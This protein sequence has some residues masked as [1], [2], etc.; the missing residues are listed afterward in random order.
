MDGFVGQNIQGYEIHEQINEGGFGAVYRADQS[1]IGREVAIKVILP[2]LASK[3][4]FIRRFEAEAQIIARLEHPHI[5]PLHDYWRDPHG[6][7]LVM[8]YLRGGSLHDVLHQ[9]GSFQIE[10]AVSLFSQIAHGLHIA[11]RNQVV[12]RDIKP[13][14]IL[15]DE[16]GNGYLADFG[17]A[18]D[19]A[20]THNITEP[21]SLVGSPEYLAP[22]QARSEPVTPQTDIYS[23]G[24]VLYEM[25]TGEHPFPGLE[26][27]EVVFKHLNEPLPNIT[28]LEERICSDINSVI[29]K[30]TAKDP[31]KRYKDVLE[32]L[33]A[34]RQ[35]SRLGENVTPTRLVELLTPREQEVM[36]LIIDGKTNREIA[37][38]LVLAETTIKSYI[39][40]IYKKLNVRSRVQAIARARDIDFVIN[41]PDASKIL[42]TGSLPE[43]EN[44]YKGLRAF[45]AAD[46]H[47]FF[48]R[49]KLIRMLVGR[50]GENGTYQRFLSLVG[51]SGSGKS[52]VVRAGLIP[53][54]WRGDLLGSE[55]WYIVDVL[56]G[57]RP[58]DELEVALYRIA[59]DSSVNLR[60]Q[61]ERDEHGLI[62]AS[63]MILPDDGSELLV[64]IDQFE[65]VFTLV[66]NEAHRQHFLDLL[67]ESIVAPRSRV[68]IVVTLR[69]DYYDR[70]LQYPHFGDLMRNR[71]ETI[72][73]LSAEE[74]EKAISEPATRVGVTF[75][76]GLVSRIVSDVHYQPG[77]L[78]LLQYALTELFELREGRQLTL[79]GYTQ[80]GG[81]GGALAKRAD[82][83][84][85]EGDDQSREMIRQ[86]FLRLVT[87]GEGAEDTRRRVER[88]ELLQLSTEPDLMDEII[89]SYAMSRL[90]SLDNDPATRQPIVEVAHEAILREWD[91]LRQWLNE[92]RE[93]IR[94]E[95][96]IAQVASSWQQND[97]DTSYLLS[98]SRLD[99]AIQWQDETQLALMPI[100]SQ[101]IMVSEQEAKSRQEAIEKQQ[102]REAKLERRSQRIL[103]A[104]VGVFA[105]ATIIALGLSIFAINSRNE[106]TSERD[107]AQRVSL[108]AQGQVVLLSG[109]APELAAMLA[110]ESLKRGYSAEADSILQ[111]ALQHG[112]AQQEF[113]GHTDNI[114]NAEFTG[115]GQKLIS[116]S[117]DNTAKLWDTSTGEIL[118][119]FTH[120]NKP[121]TGVISADGHYAATSGKDGNIMIW[122]LQDE[123]VLQT[124]PHS[125]RF[126]WVGPFSH[127]NQYITSADESDTVILWDVR[128]GNMV[129]E[130]TSPGDQFGDT[131]ISPDGQY[132][133]GVGTKVVLWDT[134][135]GEVA[136]RFYGHTGLAVYADI[137]ADGKLLLTGSADRTARLWDIETGLEVRRFEGHTD[138]VRGVDLSP[139]N[140][141]SV[142]G[143]DDGV[144]RVWHNESG[145]VVKQFNLPGIVHSAKFTPDGTQIITAGSD[146]V[147]RLWQLQDHSEPRVFADRFISPKRN[148]TNLGAIT[149]AGNQ[150][151]S[152]SEHGALRWWQFDENSYAIQQEIVFGEQV[153]DYLAYDLDTSRA[154]TASNEGIVQAWDTD[155]G[156]KLFDLE[157]HSGNINDIAFSMDGDR[158]VTAGVDGLAKVW[159]AVTGGEV[160]TLTGHNGAVVSVVFSP[161]GRLLATG[162]ED[163]TTRL[164]DATTGEQV[165]LWS[166]HDGIVFDVAFSPDGEYLVSASED[167]TA[168]LWNVEL[169]SMEHQLSGH[170]DQIR[171]VTFSPDGRHVVTGSSDLTA[172]IWDVETGRLIRQLVGHLHNVRTASYSPDGNHIVT[173][174][175]RATYLWRAHLPDVINFA[176]SLLSQDFTDTERQRF[177]IENLTAT[178]GNPVLPTQSSDEELF[179]D[180]TTAPTTPPAI[181]LRQA[182]E[183]TIYEFDFE[184]APVVQVE[185]MN[186]PVSDVHIPVGDGMVMRATSLNDNLINLPLYT[187]K[188]PV[189]FDMIEPPYD[190]GPYEQGE[191]LGFTMAEWMTASGTGTYVINDSEVLLDAQFE[192][193][194][195]NSVYTTWCIRMNLPL[196]M[197]DIKPCGSS[198]GTENW[199]T[200]SELGIGNVAIKLDQPFEPSTKDVRSMIAIVFHSDGNTY[201]PSPG[202]MG[203]NAHMQLVYE[204][205]HEW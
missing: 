130:F 54:L 145:E 1:T 156:T 176:C 41:K 143:T 65:E 119:E 25:L 192:N 72:L 142:T 17:I 174:D 3:P 164:W 12:H 78:P 137:S 74:L 189:P 16:D 188:D 9:Q 11:H 201:G 87:L 76:D 198:D 48:G 68:R 160:L 90:L 39:R 66:E 97:Y 70:P 77:A 81:T 22:E 84:Y 183:E 37:E 168:I 34:L 157:G 92:S 200:S 154:V 149:P 35:A 7:Y 29:Q 10:D 105:V 125:T 99:Q 195:P 40:N 172:R 127:D 204:F 193:L 104:L 162:G 113:I 67:Y 18:K 159:D 146:G 151:V 161:D 21:D 14:N 150:I 191:P 79:A 91:R 52:S 108:A 47:D 85:E 115:D 197:P 58:L 123:R 94:Q 44:P 118:M 184:K 88:A 2:K 64:V 173:T 126:T 139:D 27:I 59:S 93:D 49:E 28:S 205:P 152:W 121:M 5:V 166:G 20:T 179:I 82:Q 182:G 158:I 203:K 117:E 167:T 43:P 96:I 171:V 141:Y 57:D 36:Q 50:L 89:D 32:M 63:E 71:V 15:L 98:G 53:A 178:C 103:R 165:S 107:I 122:D 46:S 101:L 116:F 95:R 129:R 100:E 109:Q 181:E 61:L 23:L 6:A 187:A 131:R 138:M 170:S 155:S 102:R 128:T 69:A 148:E 153:V 169:R 199:F 120:D 136:R 13:G 42:S 31:Q 51:P 134:E 111:T 56:P 194:V 8:R 186:I 114:Y 177:G 60:E 19:H 112:F 110:I 175:N 24:V 33:E 55:K 106:A 80:I 38:I 132:V 30:S 202:A 135:T 62:R 147:A 86:L 180:A 163:K 133:L 185:Q 26:R 140:T 75:E 190:A 4:D 144:V 124:L 83:I 73:P 45:Q 196:D